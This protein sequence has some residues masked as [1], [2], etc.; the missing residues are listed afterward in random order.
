MSKNWCFWTVVREKT[1]ESPLDSMK[2]NPVNSKG[3]QPWIVIGRTAAEAETLLWL[4]YAK[5][6]LIGKDPESAK[7]WGQEEKG[8]TEDEMIE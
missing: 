3:D 2:I 1:L 4:R 6:Q 8:V 7:D 5:S